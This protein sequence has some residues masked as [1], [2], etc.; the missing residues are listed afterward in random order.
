MYLFIFYCVFIGDSITHGWE[1]A[2]KETWQKYYAPRNAFNIGF[3]GDR[4]EHVLWRL[5]NGAVD[6]IA[7]KV[8]VMMIGTNNAGHRQ[9]A[10]DE[11]AEGIKAILDDLE[12]RLP[13]TKVLLLAIFPRGNLPDHK[14]RKLND[15]T[16]AKIADYADGKR[17]FFLDIASAFLDDTG[18]LPKPIMPD[19]LHPRQK[20]YALWAEA[21][22]PKLKALLGE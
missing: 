14:L 9:E 15:A 10:S 5:Q 4:T 6:G 22:E 2:G 20:G 17:V 18:K 16:N 12:T 3:S 21:M 19:F 7:P 11:T 8:A 1:N 13:E